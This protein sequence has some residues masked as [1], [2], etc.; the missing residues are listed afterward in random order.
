MLRSQSVTDKDKQPVADD[1]LQ[2]VVDNDNEVIR[3]KTQSVIDKDNRVIK[4]YQR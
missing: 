4:S 3:N 2:P 1:F